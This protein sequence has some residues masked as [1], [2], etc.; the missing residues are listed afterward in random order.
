M[1]LVQSQERLVNG[2][3]LKTDQLTDVEYPAENMD[4]VQAFVDMFA[5]TI[6][7]NE[8]IKRS[9]VP[10]VIITPYKISDMKIKNIEA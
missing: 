3:D 1:S 2:N 8:N 10:I 5:Q 9:S 4:D 7:L 6:T